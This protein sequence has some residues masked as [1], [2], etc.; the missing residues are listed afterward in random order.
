MKI[1]LLTLVFQ[2]DASKGR[3]V[4][5]LFDYFKGCPGR[6]DMAEERTRTLPPRSQGAIVAGTRPGGSGCK[7]QTRYVTQ[8]NLN[9]R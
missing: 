1:A 2:L 4:G 6:H 9:V 5:L 7:H 3:V 8:F